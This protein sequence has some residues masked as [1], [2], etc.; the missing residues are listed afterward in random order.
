VS[1]LFDPQKLA[2]DGFVVLSKFS[3]GCSA[4]DAAQRLGRVMDM[5][6]FLQG[7]G[8]VRD[9]RPRNVESAPKNIY[10]GNFGLG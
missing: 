9:L 8:V 4:I 3:P 7:Y 1:T 2:N 10:S 6:P 5:A